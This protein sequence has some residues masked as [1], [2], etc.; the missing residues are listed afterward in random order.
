MAL[1]GLLGAG[2]AVPESF[3][4]EA[5]AAAAGFAAAAAAGFAAAAAAG[6]A[7]AAAAVSA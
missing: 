6:F 4:G 3:L 5:A 7:A 1:A 2:E